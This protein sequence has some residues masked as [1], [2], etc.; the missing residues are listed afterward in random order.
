MALTKPP[1]TI[2][3]AGEPI[4][5]QAWNEIVGGL[6]DLFDA[7]LAI[8]TGLV[9]VEVV[10]NG[11]MARGAVVVAEPLGEGNPVVAVPPFAGRT[12][13][14]IV[15]V[16]SGK[17]RLHIALDGYTTET[18]EVDI[19]LDDRLIV[20][21]SRVGPALPDLF[22]LGATDA[23][24]KLS[25]AGISVE[26]LIDTT[27]NEISPF[28]INVDQA[29]SPVLM[30]FPDAGTSM[31]SGLRVR[32]VIAAAIRGTKTVTMPNLAG[33]RSDDVAKVLDDLGLRIGETQTLTNG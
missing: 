20:E 25:E 15:G 7:V 8:G 3:T 4:T 32:L 6:N 9:E 11:A 1:I 22:G 28:D 5:S 26:R 18:R 27:G 13:H 30:Q 19:P 12:A 14:S 2:A 21:V 33:L 16:S 31:L 23:V 29:K 24:K 10:E 17:W